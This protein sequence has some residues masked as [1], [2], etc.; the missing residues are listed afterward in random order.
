MEK[1]KIG[2]IFGGRSGEHEISIRSASTVIREI[3]K[4]RFK[5]LPI[6]ITQEGKWLN[7][8]E[9][10]GMLPEDARAAIE[11]DLTEFDGRRV[12]LLGDTS[13]RGL[14]MLGTG[15]RAA[16]EI[17]LDIVF[18]VLHGTFGEDGTIQGLLEMAGIPYVGCGVLAS[19]TGMDKVFMKTLFRDADLPQCEYVWLL[20]SEWEDSREAV[21]D[22]IEQKL[23]FPC[24]VKPANLGSS[25]GVSKATDRQSLVEGIHLAAEFDRKVIVEENLSMREIECAVFGNDHPEAS[26]PGEYIVLDENKKFLDFEEKYSGTGNNEFVVPAKV[27]ESLSDRIREMAVTAYKAVDASGFAR[28]DFFLVDGSG[29]LLI[30]EINTIPGL[31]DASGFPKMWAGSGIGFTEVLDK[32]V[33]FAFER[34]KDKARNRTNR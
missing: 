9:S 22:Q 17:P 2:V 13:I 16:E 30:N 24:F 12:G 6:A 5:V 1:T 23:G 15:D 14:T 31:T 33:E 28:V 26:L 19:S 32:L 8:F 18:P 27:D 11:Y 20:R 21:V 34:A 7:P 3:D 4:D 25:V 29:E 10:A